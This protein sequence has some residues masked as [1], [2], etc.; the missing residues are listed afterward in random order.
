MDRLGR[1]YA[2][3]LVLVLSQLVGKLSA[4]EDLTP[5]LR[6]LD[7]SPFQK[8]LDRFNATRAEEIHDLVIDATISDLQAALEAGR[9]TSEELTLYFLDRIQRFDQNLRSYTELNPRALQ[10]ARAADASRAKDSKRDPLHGIPLNLKDNIDTRA[11]LHT[12]GGAEILLNHSPEQDAE[13]VTRLRS[14]GAVI[15]GKASLSEFAGALTMDPSGANA[16]SGAGVNPYAPELDVSGS[17]SGSAISTSAYLTTASV[18]TE[19]SGSLISPA[20]QNGCVS[21]KPS[22]GVVSGTGV[23]PL[24]RF[25]DSAG[26]VARN[27]TDAAIML[28]AMDQVD[29]DYAATL[30]TEALRNVAVGV[31][32]D[33]IL[34]SSAPALPF[35]WF[36]EQHAVIQKIDR[37]LQKSHAIS[38]A[39]QLPPEQLKSLSRLIFMGLAQDTIGY[40]INAGAPVASLNDLRN[41]NEQQPEIRVPF[42]QLLVRYGC[43]LVGEFADQVGSSENDLTNQYQQLALQ[44]RKQAADILDNIFNENEID[45]I[46]SLANDQSPLYATAGYPAI[47]IPLGLDDDGSPIGVTFIGRKGDDTKLLSWAFAFEQATKYRVNPGKPFRQI[48]KFQAVTFDLK[49]P[50]VHFGNSLSLGSASHHVQS[51]PIRQQINGTVLGMSVR[52]L[53][54]DRMPEVYISVRIDEETDSLLI[55]TL[56]SRHALTRVEFPP[57]DSSAGYYGNDHYVLQDSTITR[58]FPLFTSDPD[59]IRP[60]GK[61]RQ[62]TYQ[63]KQ[64]A[65]RVSLKQ[66]RISEISSPTTD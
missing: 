66:T 9:L 35:E 26:P 37:G 30:N 33:E 55:Y 56:N 50:N 59:D 20:S 13:L 25:Q 11:P 6:E 39:I 19:T 53:N 43:S 64:D 48:Q 7:F 16:V 12:T 4:A 1:I 65:D 60:T 36:S 31:L 38:N 63:L 49:S 24:V 45:L 5:R 2:I 40:L 34:W 18:G 58:I 8:S 51:V 29:V 54:Q 21:M 46:V 22:R 47:T 3:L 23:I 17:S 52:D 57:L 62:I 32:R 15:L 42:G 61:S 14:A 27:V 44:L 10:E 28:A 41:Y